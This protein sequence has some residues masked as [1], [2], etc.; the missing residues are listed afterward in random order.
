MAA[1]R[2]R[3]TD[4]IVARLA[5][6]AREYTV[7]DTSL[8]GLGVRVRPSG[9]RSFVYCRKG[10]GKARRITLGP[11]ALMSIGKARA[12]CLAIETG[13]RPIPAE[14]G[15]VPTFADFV[16][17][18]ERDFFDRGKPS[19]R[20]DANRV[21][22]VRLLPAFGRLP[23]DRIARTDV[24][25][26]FDEYSLTAP[27]AANHVLN[28]LARILNHAVDCGHLRTNPARGIRRNPR[29]KLTRFLSREEV[30]RLHRVLDRHARARPSRARQA[31][32]IR[33]LLLTGC[34]KSEILTLRW[35]DVNGNTIN[36]G[37]AKTGPRRVFLNA[38]ARA[39]LERQPRSNCAYV[40][41]SPRN[42]GSRFRDTC[43]SGV[44]YARK[45]GSRTCAFTT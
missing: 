4:A 2:R 7:W 9:H 5:P 40:F 34:R 18:P 45:P 3:L 16:A 20:R 28:L 25:R 6:T 44:W 32:V 42:S 39:V 35:Q 37:D 38:P 26:W 10:Q 24:N 8:A 13:A 31:D 27:G 30:S 22:E 29:P 11:T 21:I 23:L 43:R 41:P 17:G 15:A 12:E 14:R 1:K 33:L 19:T 36:L